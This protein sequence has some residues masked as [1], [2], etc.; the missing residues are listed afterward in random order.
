MLDLI[1]GQMDQVNSKF[2]PS[3]LKVHHQNKVV[4][5]SLCFLLEGSARTLFFETFSDSASRQTFM[6]NNPSTGRPSRILIDGSW[7]AVVRGAVMYGLN[8]KVV[9]E[10]ILRR[11]YGIPT[12]VVWDNEKHPIERRWRDHLDGSWR[13][14]VMKWYVAKVFPPF[15]PINI[16]DNALR[17]TER[18]R[19]CF[20]TTLTKTRH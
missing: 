11:H 1:N 15:T 12:S 20:S 5:R 10:R 18:S 2:G 16:R 19:S 8:S 13:I 4:K 3:S 6:S 17:I 9:R 7:S 14:D